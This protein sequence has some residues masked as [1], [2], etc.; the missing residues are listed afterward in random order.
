VLALKILFDKQADGIFHGQILITAFRGERD[1]AEFV[2]AERNYRKSVCSGLC[3]S[4]PF[5]IGRQANHEVQ[6]LVDQEGKIHVRSHC[7]RREDGVDFI[8]ENMF[9]DSSL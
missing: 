2:S 4:F 3:F 6:R 5:F 8:P 9:H 7:H 1:E